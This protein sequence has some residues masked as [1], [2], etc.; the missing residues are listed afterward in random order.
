M[1]DTTDMVEL[2]EELSPDARQELIAAL[3]AAGQPN[4]DAKL[5]KKL[6]K[7]ATFLFE[8]AG[9]ERSTKGKRTQRSLWIGGE[10]GFQVYVSKGPSRRS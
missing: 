8:N 4:V 7:A 10:E 5:S 1:S 9:N 3:Q 2:A 6:T